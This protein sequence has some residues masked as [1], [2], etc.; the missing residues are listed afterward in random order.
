MDQ[1]RKIAS[2]AI[3][4]AWMT[5]GAFATAAPENISPELEKLLDDSQI[6]AMAAAVIVDGD[7]VAIGATGIRKVGDRKEVEVDD[8]FH[9]G[10][11][12]KSMTAV[13]AAIL[14]KEGKIKWETTAAEV[15]TKIKVH[16]SFKD[17][18]LAQFLTNTGGTAGNVEGP[19]WQDLWEAKGAL[20]KQ[21]L[22]LVEGTLENPSSYP[23]GGKYVYS[24][25]GF[26]IA[27]AML[28]AVTGESW[29]NLMEEN[30]FQP[31]KMKSAG[32]RAPASNRR[33][34]QPYGHH[35]RGG[36]FVP[37]D[38]EPSGDNP[39]GI[40]PAN[41][42]H[43][44]VED[45]A[46][47]L[48]F[49]LGELGKDILSGEERAILYEPT[50]VAPYAMG[51]GVTSRPGPDGKSYSHSGS[52]TMFFTTATFFPSSRNAL[53]VMTNAGNEE[54]QVKVQQTMEKL[55]SQFLPQ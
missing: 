41:A 7:I 1:G 46:R 32:F 12:T 44:N 11:N 2:L 36:R 8:K 38:P 42:V 50:K 55:A 33:T 27:G 6:P 17:A 45:Y 15:F 43:C 22:L 18:T 25:T 51:W 3:V 54:A 40:A 29:E 5:C 10:S 30:I 20:E 26:S 21:R 37:V 28:E 16:E 13:L 9:L 49:H 34:D 14:V 53:V 24:N 4:G 35:E 39:A 19:L 31:L 48:Q 52:N 23:P 47:Y